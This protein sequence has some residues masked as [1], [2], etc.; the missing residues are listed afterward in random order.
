MSRLIKPRHF[1]LPLAGL[2]LGACGGDDDPTGPGRN[3]ESGSVS[4]TYSGELSG[5]FSASGAC[6]F[7]E[8]DDLEYRTC[9]LGISESDGVAI[10]GLETT[11]G[12]QA[13]LLVIALP[14]NPVVGNTYD[15]SCIACSITLIQGLDLGTDD[16]DRAILFVGPRS[17]TVTSVS[18]ERIRGTFSGLG[19][20]P[21]G[22]TVTIDEGE[23]DV[24][25]LEV[26]I[27]A[28]P[29]LISEF[30]LISG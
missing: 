30:E 3:T 10:V 9:A 29:A 5:S 18:D 21:D 11:G 15:G 17:I 25:F 20:S 7:D 24:P 27:D 22:F 19:A 13:D 6:Q 26:D 23:F 2:L 8:N 1:L 12:G 16:A 28:S 14:R 4:L